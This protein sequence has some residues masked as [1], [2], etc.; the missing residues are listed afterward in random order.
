MTDVFLK[1]APPG[2]GKSIVVVLSGGAD[3]TALLAHAIDENPNHIVHL[4][5]VMYGSKHEAQEIN[6]AQSVAGYYAGKEGVVMGVHKIAN[7][8]AI[9]HGAEAHSTLMFGGSA[10]PQLTYEEI[11][12]IEGP[13]PTV[14]PNR[15]MNI[16]AGATTFAIVHGAELIYMGMHGLDAAGF[17]YPDCTFGFTG[18][19]AAAVYIA[20][21]H[22]VQFKVPWQFMSKAEAIGR[23][24][25]LDAPFDLTWSCYEG[26]SRHCGL[27]PTCVER[28]EAFRENG[29]IDPVEYEIDLGWPGCLPFSKKYSGTPHPWVKQL[30]LEL[31][32]DDPAKPHSGG[33]LT[34]E[35]LEALGGHTGTVPPLEFDPDTD[36][37]RKVRRSPEND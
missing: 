28:V 17:A 29:V 6:A 20:S 34:P 5:S 15:N 12:K 13:S 23:G 7:L 4:F 26:R 37:W 1:D 2:A 30:K 8:T 24:L 14:V 10:N 33:I 21:Y 27:C 19:M 16:I 18:A 31:A 22:E 3:S 35:D 9:F 32:E 11:Q 25:L 36:E